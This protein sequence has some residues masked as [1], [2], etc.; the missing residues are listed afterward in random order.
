MVRKLIDVSELQIERK[1]FEPVLPDILKN[2]AAS[3]KPIEGKITQ[4][5]ADQSKIKKTF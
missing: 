5:V 2:G 4:S 3:M 1:K